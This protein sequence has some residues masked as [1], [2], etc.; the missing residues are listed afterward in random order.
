M[1]EPK[2]PAALVEARRTPLFD[3][4]TL[5]DSLATSH[6][7]TVWAELM[8][9]AGTVRYVDLEGD[10]PRDERV[11]AGETAVIVPGI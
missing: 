6:R 10:S 1:G 7:T 9:Q 5:P 11:G 3:Y 4:S 8:V 2:L